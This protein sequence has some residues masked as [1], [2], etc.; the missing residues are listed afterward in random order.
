MNRK[1]KD[2]IKRAFKNA[3]CEVFGE[4]AWKEALAGSEVYA[5]IAG[6]APAITI[7]DAFRIVSEMRGEFLYCIN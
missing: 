4:S 1:E 5:F 6:Y 2:D 7:A 3:N